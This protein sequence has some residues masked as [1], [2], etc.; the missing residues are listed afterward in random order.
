MPS[1]ALSTYEI[2]RLDNMAHNQRKL[3]F[4]GLALEPAAHPK[5]VRRRVAPEIVT[6]RRASERRSEA[7]PVRY[8]TLHLFGRDLAEWP[9]Q[10]VRRSHTLLVVRLVLRGQTGACSKMVA[11]WSRPKH[12]TDRETPRVCASLGQSRRLETGQ[13]AREAQPA[14]QHPCTG[15]VTTPLV[16]V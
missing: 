12:T 6:A 1:M 7:S 13:Q 5:Q 8:D 2:S 10:G 14:G 16:W 15:S 3:K 4:L 9:L 11:P